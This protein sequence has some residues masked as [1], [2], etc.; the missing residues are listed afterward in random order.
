MLGISHHTAPL[1]V[2]EHFA[3]PG[4]FDRALRILGS[5]FSEAVVLTTCNRTELYAVAEHPHE[6]LERLGACADQIFPEYFSHW[7]DRFYRHAGHR[8]VRHLMRVAC[9]LES[10][11]IGEAEIL[12]QVRQALEAS[13]RRFP[14][15]KVLP[16]LFREA[17]SVGR[18]ARLHTA[19]GRTPASVSSVAAELAQRVL[20]SFDG[21]RSLLIGTGTM[22]QLVTQILRSKKIASLTVATSDPSRHREGFPGADVLISLGEIP[23]VLPQIDLVVAATSC[24]RPILT[25][26]G[27]RQALALRRGG[28]MV[29]IDLGIPRNVAPEVKRLPGVFAYDLDELQQ[30]ASENLERRQAEVASVEEMV[31]SHVAKFMKWLGSQRVLPTIVALRQKAEAIRRAELERLGNRMDGMAES[32]REMVERLTERIISRLLHEPTVKLKDLAAGDRGATYAMAIAE[33]FGLWTDKLS[34][35]A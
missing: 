6:G 15:A 27:L 11:V 9:G 25:A 7:R 22:G 35:E 3:L 19:I 31:E 13:E 32:Q 30:V 29:V 26:E 2:R 10:M 18:K 14:A 4:D 21:R 17:V 20:G 1:S 5:W 16:R 24:E 8:A 23:S 12:G 34:E 33:L 28:P